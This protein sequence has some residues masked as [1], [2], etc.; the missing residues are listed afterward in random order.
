LPK[1]LGLKE[2]PTREKIDYFMSHIIIIYGLLISDIWLFNFLGG[3][4]LLIK[5][6]KINETLVYFIKFLYYVKLLK[7]IN[8]ELMRMNL[9]LIFILSIY[10]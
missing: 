7:N 2:I 9:I 1:F 10:E 6:R 5:I 8:F 4:T 3:S